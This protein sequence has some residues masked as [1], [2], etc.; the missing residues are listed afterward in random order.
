MER[1]LPGAGAPRR[2]DRKVAEQ[3]ARYQALS[4]QQALQKI[5]KLEQQMHKH[6]KNLEFEEAA[7]LRDEIRRLERHAF[8]MPDA[9]TA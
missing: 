4:P 2:R 8:G 6:A 7:K 5:K 9:A 1:E 3:A